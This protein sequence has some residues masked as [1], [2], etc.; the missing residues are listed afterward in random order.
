ME[1]FHSY[2]PISVLCENIINHITFDGCDYFCTI[3]GKCA[4]IRFDPCICSYHQYDTCRE[5]DCICYDYC[6]QCFWASSRSCSNKLFQLDCCMNEIDC[7]DICASNQ[8]GVITGISYRC[9][10]NALLVS[11]SC[12]VV[13][14]EKCCEKIRLLYTTT[15]CWITD[16]LSIC[17]GMLLMVRRENQY[18]IY[19]INAC[20]EKIADFCI[21]SVFVPK[22]LIF[23]P[24]TAACQKPEIWAFMCKRNCYPYLCQCSIGIDDFGFVPCSC[25]DK[26]YKPCGCKD[27]VCQDTCCDIMQSIAFVETAIAH[28]LNAE[29]EKLQKVLCT[30]DDIHQIIC[31]NREINQMIVNVTHLEQ[32]LYEKL[33]A[34][35]DCLCKNLCAD[36]C[37][38][39]CDA[40]SCQ[41]CCKKD[42]KL[43]E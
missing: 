6:D 8:Y 29:G 42:C 7:I 43:F 1:Y 16:V 19:V 2:T 27:V 5:Y 38:P 40:C 41:D 13:E 37:H 24:C 26:I 33:N 30:T 14:V 18:D 34:L 12:S 17:P 10:K 35:S 9:C 31:V 23:H 21:E 15:Q 25:N 4:I 22:N 3:R 39:C 11:F 32:T 20:G 36:V 28:I